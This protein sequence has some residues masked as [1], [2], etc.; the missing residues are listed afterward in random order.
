MIVRFT[1]TLVDVAEDSV[2]MERDGVAREV[3]TPAYAI[4][5]LAA[6]RGREVTL[7]TLEFYESNQATGHL[8]P[9]LIGFV[10]PEDKLFYQRFIGVKGIGARK[11]LKALAEPIGLIAGHIESGD[12][13]ALARL[14][15]IGRRAAEL[16][17]AQ[18]K[19]KVG[20]FA[21]SSARR[22]AVESTVWTDAQRCAVDVLVAWG[23]TREDAERWLARAGELHPEI[24]QTDEWVRA[25]Y[26][27]KTGMEGAAVR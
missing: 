14:P 26:R 7:H 10:E 1:G 20:E 8:V 17:I 13:K 12:A 4:T 23:D 2:V 16:M 5:S 18:L 15:G 3:L 22:E 25:A 24:D 21:F 9:R 11:A 6:Q 19:G 27:V